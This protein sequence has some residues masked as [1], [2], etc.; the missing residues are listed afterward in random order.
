MRVFGP[1]PSRRLGQSLGI[2]NIPSKHCTYSCVYCQLGRTNKMQMTRN[3]FY[4][5]E[6]LF[7]EMELKINE[8]KKAGQNIDYLTFVTD[9]EPTLDKNLGKTIELLKTFKIKIA[10]ITNA[11]LI[12]M[13]EVQQDLMLADWVSLKVDSVDE[14]IWRRIDRP[15]RHLNINTILKGIIDFSH[16]FQGTLVTETMIVKDINDNRECISKAADFL[17]EVKPYKSYILVPSRPPA[18]T[19]VQRPDIATLWEAHKIMTENAHTCVECITGDEGEDFYFSDD[20]IKDLL[21]ILSV[22]PVREDIID[23]LLKERNCSWEIVN[24]LINEGRI[25]RNTYEGRNYFVR[26]ACIYK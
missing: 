9:G 16:S 1:V 20:L 12:W 7:N 10:V 24:K 18:E 4:S 26:K 8:L 2:N 23:T 19:D 17:A 14:D 6:D 11:S 21:N 5:P 15:Y 3:E 22:H 25:E 13:D